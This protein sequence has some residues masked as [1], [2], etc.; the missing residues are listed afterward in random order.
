MRCPY[1]A[2]AT[3]GASPQPPSKPSKAPLFRGGERPQT[4]GVP[5]PRPNPRL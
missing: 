1:T 5:Y 3:R 2:G 4:R